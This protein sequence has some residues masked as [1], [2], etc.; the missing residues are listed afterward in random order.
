[1]TLTQT[2]KSS[3]VLRGI[4]VYS[5]AMPIPAAR[6]QIREWDQHA[7]VAP[8]SGAAGLHRRRFIGQWQLHPGNGQMGCGEIDPMLT[9]SPLTRA[10]LHHSPGS[11]VHWQ[12]DQPVPAPA[13]CSELFGERLG[14]ARGCCFDVDI[15]KRPK[16]FGRRSCLRTSM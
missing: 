11:S 13:R 3:T 1:M 9:L 16:C 8:P 4:A 2:I 7:L 14:H 6:G 12:M 15:W 10:G 5:V